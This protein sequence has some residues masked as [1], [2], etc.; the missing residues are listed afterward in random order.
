MAASSVSGSVRLASSEFVAILR[1]QQRLLGVTITPSTHEVVTLGPPYGT[2]IHTLSTGTMLSPSKLRD[3]AIE[4][5][6]GALILGGSA[7]F[8]ADGST[9]FGVRKLI[10]EVLGL[11]YAGGADWLPKPAMSAPPRPLLTLLW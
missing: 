4:Q 1:A 9:H 3:L 7:L 5:Q 2:A 6:A 11:S 10:S 8:R